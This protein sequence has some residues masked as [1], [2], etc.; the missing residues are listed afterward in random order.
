MNADT[1]GKKNRYA[2]IARTKSASSYARR[3]VS[4]VGNPPSNLYS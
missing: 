2:V 4:G 1:D 3:T